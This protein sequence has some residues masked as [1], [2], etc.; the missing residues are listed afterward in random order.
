MSSN[1]G[2][3]D[4]GA[5][6]MEDAYS[7]DEETYQ[8]FPLN[9]E[10]NVTPDGG[11]K[12]KVIAEGTG[13]EKPETGDRV[14]VHYVGTLLDGT[15]FDSSRDR[16]DS[17]TFTLGQ[18]EVIKG[19]DEGVATMHKGE[20]AIL[21]CEAEYAY[22][23][24][25]SPPKIPP[26]ATLQF[27]VELLSWRSVKD[28]TGDGGIIKSIVVE[29]K[30]FDNPRG[31]DEVLVKYEARI[32]DAEKPFASSG[33][34]G[35]EFHLSE[36]HLCEAIP[37]AVGKMKEGESV[38]LAVQPQY[39]FGETGTSEVPP[40]SSL[41][42]NLQLVSWKK[43]TDVTDDGGVVLKVLKKGEGY[44]KPK[45]GA[46]VT[47]T[48]TGKLP[49]GTVFE[50]RQEGNEHKFMVDEEQIIDGLDLAVM[51][52]DRGEVAEVTIKPEYA[53][54]ESETQREKACVPGNSTVVYTIEIVDLANPKNSW[55]MSNAEKIE[56]A[57]TRKEKGNEA[58]KAG[59]LAR[60][61]SKY[62]GAVKVI[63]HD[64]DFGESKG[65]SKELKKSIW[66]NLA[67]ANLKLKD[68]GKVIQHCGKVLE[69]DSYNVKALYRRA[70]AH[71][72]REDFIESEQ[73]IKQAIDLEPE[74][75][76]LVN[77]HKR[78]RIQRKAA[79][80]Q[81]AKMYSTM[82][83]RMAK[84]KDPSPVEAAAQQNE[85]KAMNGGGVGTSGPSDA[86]PS[87]SS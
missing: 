23:A 17:F 80:K 47:V 74:N 61:V 87:S 32:E 15:K 2:G 76:D 63:E 16:D 35:I 19:W 68:S 41:T 84:L 55:D 31:R 72:T 82:F 59:K 37:I 39:G 3:S 33:D 6:L 34:S 81:E 27:E 78:M 70:Q 66:L 48:Y 28:I 45:E 21:T 77:L 38:V 14:E 8:S 64:K 71:M 67:A 86:G 50:E 62:E 69:I 44:D 58:Y 5:D 12:K 73:D 85:N 49:D 10:K 57:R 11:I 60:A 13:Y 30:G 22:G 24:S 1:E 40:N 46:T 18:G 79:S 42:I 26:N 56:D 29:G 53:F 54:G 20:K 75:K 9:E 51:K 7:T 52:M 25:G 36:G 43:V 83:S 4:F 65:A